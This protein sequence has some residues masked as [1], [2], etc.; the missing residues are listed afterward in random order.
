[1]N[2]AKRKS[3]KVKTIEVSY[4]AWLK[5]L[6]KAFGEFTLQ[7]TLES[8][9][10]DTKLSDDLV[11]YFYKRINFDPVN[12]VFTGVLGQ[13][14]KFF[15]S[16]IKDAF[17]KGT[18]KFKSQTEELLSKTLPQRATY[19]AVTQMSVEEK[20][21]NFFELEKDLIK[22]E[23]EENFKQRKLQLDEFRQS[24]LFNSPEN[25]EKFKDK[26]PEPT[27]RFTN[28]MSRTQVNNLNRDLAAAMAT[29]LGYTKCEWVTSGDE[30]VRPTHRDLD[31]KIFDYNNLPTEYNDYNC[32]CS[33]LPVMDIEDKIK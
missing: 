25:I 12:K 24:Y 21:A 28:S 31:T 3:A 16:V 14:E 4:R 1:M 22:N 27:Y 18:R 2:E 6:F 10:R 17:V 15:E 7:Q 20:R 32:R 33:L 29:S 8:L 13:N 11:D 30:R 26:Y 9:E 23:M 5:R 19:N